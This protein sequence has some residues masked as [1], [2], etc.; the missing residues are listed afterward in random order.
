[1]RIIWWQ[2]ILNQATLDND[3]RGLLERVSE[4]YTF[5]NEDR[6]LVEVPSMQALYGKVA[7]QT[8]ECADFI[9]HYSETKSVCKS[10]PLRHRLTLIFVSL[11]H[12]DKT[13]QAHFRRNRCRGSE[14]Q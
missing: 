12:R 13:R 4:I 1:M 5:M 6:R 9:A 2:M 8:L 10:I 11:R 7:R 3:V 14:L